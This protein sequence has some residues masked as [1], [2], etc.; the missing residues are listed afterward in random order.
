M[1]RTHNHGPP[2]YAD[3]VVVLLLLVGFC[4]G[5]EELGAVVTAPVGWAAVLELAIAVMD[6]TELLGM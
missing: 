4:A 3:G 2:F 1:T 5:T 6:V